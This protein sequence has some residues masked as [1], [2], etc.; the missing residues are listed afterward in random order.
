MPL[1]CKLTNP[2]P[3]LLCVAGTLQE[4]IFLFLSHP[5]ARYSTTRDQLYSPEATRII[6][7]QN[8]LP[9]ELF[10]LASPK[11]FTCPTLPFLWKLQ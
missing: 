7:Y 4:A 5:L 6:H 3:Y 11:L 8:Y 2:E 9:P 10:K 1:I